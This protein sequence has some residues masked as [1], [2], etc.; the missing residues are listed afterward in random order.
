MVLGYLNVRATGGAVASSPYTGEAL[1]GV[2]VSFRSFLCAREKWTNESFFLR[3]KVREY[4]NPPGINS[5][6][7]NI[8]MNMKHILITLLLL[9]GATNIFAQSDA[10]T[11]KDSLY[12]QEVREMIAL[13]YSMPDYSV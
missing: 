2:D 6:M 12:R 11:R 9:L 1:E 7:K 4:V 3:Q 13:D 5:I 8:M 10:N